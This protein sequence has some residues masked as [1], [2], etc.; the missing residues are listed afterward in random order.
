MPDKDVALR[1][2]LFASV[3]G[4]VIEWY[5]FF[6][7]AAAVG[8]VI[9]AA[10]FP[11]NDPTVGTLIALSTLAVGFVAR[12]LGAIIFG[13]LG[14]KIGRKPLLVITLTIMGSATL[15]TGLLPTYAQIGT[16]AP[17]ILV[18]VRIVQGIAVG[19]E[20]G[21]AVLM[22]LEHKSGSNRRGFLGSIP[23]ACASAGFLLASGSLAVI[24][25][26]TT[27]DQFQRWGWRIPFV[28]SVALIVVGF[29]IRRRV[30][31]SPAFTASQK[32][33]PAVRVPLFEIFSRYP[34]Q[35]LVSIGVPASTAVAYNLVLVFLVPYAKGLGVS[36]GDLLTVTTSAQMV[37]I[38]LLLSWGYLSDRLGRSVPMAFGMIGVAVWAVPFFLL[39]N[40]DSPIWIF[41]AVAGA[42]FFVSAMYGP[43]AAFLAELFPTEVRYS[44]ISFGY[45][46]VFAVAGG[47][48]PMIAVGLTSATDS[49]FPAAALFTLGAAIS[50][51]ALFFRRTIGA[52]AITNRTVDEGHE[53]V[54]AD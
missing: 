23:N 32:T 2:V 29:Y 42:L 30:E 11:A 16:L 6:L 17:I 12:P 54:G 49:W 38:P 20:Y 1:R 9:S 40:T 5:D 43:Q 15:I 8:L 4:T 41:V 33:A 52:P 44:G 47:T 7:Y 34:K 37:Y 27:E 25:Y 13:H 14:D 3:I 50:L 28:A 31:E 26:L 35:V 46:L 36:A 21:G 48:T 19:G 39:V 24:S 45:Q 10:F 22:I 51:S 53:K 18:I